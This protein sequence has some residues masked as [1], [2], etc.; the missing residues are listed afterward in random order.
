MSDYRNQEVSLYEETA[1]QLMD[2]DM[3]DP[4][5]VRRVIEF[6]DLQIDR[7]DGVFTKLQ[8]HVSEYGLEEMKLPAVP[9]PATVYRQTHKMCESCGV[10]PTEEYGHDLCPRCQ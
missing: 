1:R 2:A 9:P 8:H 5:N 10:A 3:T 6:M 7:L 4:E